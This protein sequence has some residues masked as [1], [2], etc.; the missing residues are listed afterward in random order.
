MKTILQKTAAALAM[1]IV[2]SSCSKDE[3]ETT[4]TRGDFILA[5][6]PAASTGVADYLINTPQLESGKI[7]TEENGI[8][9]DGTYRYYVTHNGKFFSML[10]GQQNPGAVTTYENING[11]LTKKSNFRTETVQAFAPV[12]DDLLLVKIPRNIANPLANWYRVNTNSL[13]IEGEGTVDVHTPSNNGESAFFSWIKQVGNKVY[14]PYFSIVASGD[15]VFGTNHPDGAWIAVYSYPGMQLEK[16]ITDDRT[17]FIGRYFTDGLA[18]VENGDVYAFSASVAIKNKVLTST[19]PSAITRLKAGTDEFDRSYF[20]DFEAASGGMNIT[21]WLYIG[22]N[23]FI[24][25]ATTRAE[26]GNY[27]IGKNIGIVN[28]VN[29]TFTKVDGLPPVDQIYS[30]TNN[31]Y[32]PKDGRYGYIG[33]N[34]K[35]GW[36]YIYKI[37]ASTHTATQGL[38]VEGGVITAVQYLKSK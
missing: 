6:T 12:N 10:Y 18:V 30:I 28:V 22:N 5:V 7:S 19:K 25:N 15:E 3:N 13:L 16:V 11:K 17:S 9:Q 26:K 24:V 35:E 38:K 1:A 21:N 36:G 31:N 8:E 34:L 32:T 14:A 33:V 29:K 23:N 37:D 4:A 20:F 2:V 27:T